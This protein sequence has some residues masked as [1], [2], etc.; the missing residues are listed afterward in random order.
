[1]PVTTDIVESWVRPRVVMRRLL[2]RGTSEA[3]ALTF[4]LIFLLLAFAA[5]TPNTLRQAGDPADPLTPQL[6]GMGLGILATIPLWYL[7]AALGHLV[8]QG[9]GGK[10]SHFG[11]RLA[12][13]SA[14]VVI[15]PA[16]LAQGMVQGMIGGPVAAGFGLA[17]ALLFVGFWAVM[18]REVE[19]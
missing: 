17:V 16:M 6:F 14:L 8:A 18:L 12:L 3:F 7:L 11:A 15:S 10:G 2:N 19:Q 1:M 4:L 5:A 9:L 13:F